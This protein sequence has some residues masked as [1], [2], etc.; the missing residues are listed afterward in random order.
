MTMDMM[1]VIS[2]IGWHQNTAKPVYASRDV[3]CGY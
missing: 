1:E 2:E 3:L